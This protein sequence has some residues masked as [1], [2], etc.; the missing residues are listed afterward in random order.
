MRRLA[1]VALLMLC[2]GLAG[3]LILLFG[4]GTATNRNLRHPLWIRHESGTTYSGL[5]I[6]TEYGP[7]VEIASSV[8]V[9]IKNSNIG[10]CGTKDAGKS[11]YGIWIE[12]GSGHTIAD[13]YIH[14]ETVYT[15]PCCDGFNGIYTHGA[16]NVLI[17]G[18]VIEKG[19]SNIQ[20]GNGSDQI[21]VRGN[22]LVNPQGPYP[23]GLNFQAD[24]ATNI[25][26]VDNYAVNGG[27]LGA[28]NFNFYFTDRFTAQGNYVTGTSGDTSDCGIVI[29]SSSNRGSIIGNIVTATGQ[30]GIGVAD[31][32]GHLVD[33]NKVFEP[34]RIPGGGNTAIYVARFGA[35][36]CGGVGAEQIT[37]SNNIAYAAGTSYVDNGSCGTV[38]TGGNIFD[39]S[40][41]SALDPM[42]GTNPPPPVPPQPK[43]CTVNSP[44]TTRSSPARC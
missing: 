11:G 35:G 14:P 10:P 15:G 28:D 40:A 31:G 4:Q 30:C 37:V 26:V 1:L 16:S 23:R 44:H 42:A 27:H 3:A 34:V 13:N 25:T 7:C 2:G 18:N 19:E 36:P 39:A 24:R 12:H 9:T 33:R 38:A 41:F 29:D 22:Y 6:S 32:V 43:H 21:V 20:I 17:Q 8:N 5:T